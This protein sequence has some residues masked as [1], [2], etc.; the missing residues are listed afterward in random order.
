MAERPL[1]SRVEPFERSVSAQDAQQ[2]KREIE[3][4]IPRIMRFGLAGNPR[5]ELAIP[6]RLG[7]S[8]GRRAFAEVAPSAARRAHFGR[9]RLVAGCLE[10]RVDEVFR[11]KLRGSR[12]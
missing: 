11:G 4:S 2:I 7:A 9:H 6:R 1:P 5:H 8:L 10:Q 12:I 3:K